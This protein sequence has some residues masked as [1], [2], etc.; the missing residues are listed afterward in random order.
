MKKKTP[1]SVAAD[2]AGMLRLTTP[3]SSNPNINELWRI[4][5][6]LEATKLTVKFFGYE[7]AKALLAGLPPL[8]AGGPF[9]A[10]LTSRPSTQA[11]LEADWTRYW[12]AQLKERHAIHRRIWEYAFVLQALA[13]FGKLKAGMKGLE[14][15]S[16]NPLASYLAS[17]GCEVVAADTHQLT[18]DQIY[19]SNLLDR[20]S[21]DS[22]VR[23]RVVDLFALP[24]D[25]Q[26]FDFC[27]S[28]GRLQHIGSLARGVAFV[29][30]IADTLKPGGV[31]VHT[32]EFSF[33]I[34]NQTVDNW[35]TVLFQRRHFEEMAQRLERKG[36]RVLPLDFNIG[37]RPLDRFIDVPPFD[38]PGDNLKVWSQDTMH[39]KVNIDGF[40]CTSFGLAVV[41]G[42]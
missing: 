17:K 40:P 5:K 38:M 25:L 28:I 37:A 32:T 36:C 34:D 9:Q 19:R 23:T 3:G 21:F 29:E 6:D 14:F 18:A 7:L 27:W 20:G 15:G 26:G 30:S 8:S 16:G 11:D 12:S 35:G 41:K 1:L 31:A 24:P 4:A 2:V 39:I 22:R 33:A 10:A 42:G 13:Q